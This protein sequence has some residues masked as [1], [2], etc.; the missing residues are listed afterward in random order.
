[1][2]TTPSST[3]RCRRSS[4]ACTPTCQP[5]VDVKRL[6]ADVRGAARHGGRLGESTAAQDVLFGVVSRSRAPLRPRAQRRRARRLARVQGIGARFMMRRRSIITKR[7]PRHDAAKAIGTWPASRRWRAL[8]PCS[9]ASSRRRL[10]AALSTSTAGP[11]A[12]S[13]TLFRRASRRDESHA[14]CRT[15]PASSRHRRP[16]GIVL[17]GECNVWGGAPPGSSCCSP[18]LLAACPSC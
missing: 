18:R 14:L 12:P 13:I 6:Y 8:G 7:L 4:A 1:M 17:R 9:A 11:A 5:G 2:S 3:S 16:R 15:T 10:L